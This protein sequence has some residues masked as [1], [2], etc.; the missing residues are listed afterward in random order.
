MFLG[1]ELKKEAIINYAKIKKAIYEANELIEKYQQLEYLIPEEKKLLCELE[2]KLEQLK[3]NIP[4]INR[5]TDEVI[6]KCP[7]YYGTLESY[8]LDSD[9]LRFCLG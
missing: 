2:F 4:E 7:T 5:Y 9:L 1:N 3:Q 8:D 6:N